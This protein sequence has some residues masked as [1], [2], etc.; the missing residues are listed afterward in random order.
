MEFIAWVIFGAASV[1]AG[2]ALAKF[3]EIG[4]EK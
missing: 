1:M 2:V 4:Q 3:I